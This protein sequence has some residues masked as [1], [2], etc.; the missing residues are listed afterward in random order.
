[1][2]PEQWRHHEENREL[3]ARL[4]AKWRRQRFLA[5]VDQRRL[6]I[7]LQNMRMACDSTYLLDGQT[8]FGGKSEELVTLLDELFE[9]PETKVVVFSQWLRMHELLVRRFEA[10]GWDH[11]LFHGGVEA[12]HRGRLVDRFREDPGCRA[13]LS[14]DAGGVGLNLQHASAVVN[15]DIPWNPAVLEQRIGR[16]HRLGQRRPVQVVNLVAQGTIE[17]GMLSLLGFKRAVFAGVLDGGDA[18]VFLGGSRLARFMETVEKTTAMSGAPPAESV[19]TAGVEEQEVADGDGGGDD[20]DGAAPEDSP[21]GPASPAQADDP[22]SRLLAGG[23]AL[24]GELARAARTPAGDG[25][26]TARA[27]GPF[28]VARDPTTGETFLRVRVPDAEALNRVL[29]A[30]AGLVESLRRDR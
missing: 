8:D 12:R 13:F 25:G 29:E 3:V 5:E 10:R 26:S 20:G 19:E 27:A 17:E 30:T 16:V 22:L 14:T 1:M 2:T 9:R 4:V 6:M 21:V 7:A 24:L 28:Q 11:V 18:E 15:V 23:L